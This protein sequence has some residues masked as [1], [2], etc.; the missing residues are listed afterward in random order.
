MRKISALR[1]FQ[2]DRFDLDPIIWDLSERPEIAF[3]KIEFMGNVSNRD[4][5]LMKLVKLTSIADLANPANDIAGLITAVP[6][7]PH[8][9]APELWF[10][11]NKFWHKAVDGLGI[12][13]YRDKCYA[14]YEVEVANRDELLALLECI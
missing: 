14:L 2:F 9:R 4:G 6:Y 11:D 8:K 1:Q 13:Y 10:W 12:D 7:N 3:H 5:S